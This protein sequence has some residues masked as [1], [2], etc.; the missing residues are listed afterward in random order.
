MRFSWQWQWRMSSSGMLHHVDL[1]RTDVSEECIASIIRVK[2]IGELG[3]M[4]GV[5]S[6][7]RMLQRNTMWVALCRLLVTANIVPSSPI[8]VTLTMEAIH[9]SETSVL[10]R[11]TLCNIPEDGILHIAHVFMNTNK[12]NIAICHTKPWSHWTTCKVFNFKTTQILVT[13]EYVRLHDICV[14]C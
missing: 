7:W 6:N 13:G 1:V 2:R 3:P 12:S 9:S 10:T 4:L 5:T 14:Y 11:A 8:L